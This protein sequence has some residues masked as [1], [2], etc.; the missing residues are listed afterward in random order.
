[1]SS[2]T[3]QIPWECF[4][5][6]AHRVPGGP[7]GRAR[8]VP[9]PAFH[10]SLPIPDDAGMTVNVLRS[11]YHELEGVDVAPY[12]GP[13]S[14]ADD[15]ADVPYV[16]G[17]EYGTDAL[18]PAE[19]AALR[20]PYILHDVRG[21]VLRV[22]PMQYN[23]VTRTL[24]VFTRIEVEVVASG[25]GEVNVIDRATFGAHPDRAFHQLYANQFLNFPS[26]E[27]P[28]PADAGDL[29]VISHGPF[30]AAMQPLVDWKNSIGVNTTMVDVG[31]IGNNAGAI[32]AYI[33]N[34]YQTTNLAYVLLVGDHLQVT[35]FTSQGGLSDP[36]YS[37][38]TADW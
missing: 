19:V 13:I 21:V 38:L 4:H 17:P 30:M 34:L 10:D 6:I 7:R 22:A 12:R 18:Y 28:P 31:V 32:K 33:Q 36:S 24:R 2:T 20:D 26:Y 14:R 35:S 3:G 23:P 29:L 5:V 15:P 37:T 27:A 8:A 16:F 9:L 25:P 1:V 11:E